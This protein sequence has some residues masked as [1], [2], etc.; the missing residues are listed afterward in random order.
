[1]LDQAAAALPVLTVPQQSGGCGQRAA[2]QYR[3]GI[4]AGS[5]PMNRALTY[6]ILAIA[7]LIACALIP[8]HL[9]GDLVN[10]RK[11]LRDR[12]VHD[13]A[14]SSAGPQRID[15]IAVVLPCTETSDEVE[16]TDKG[17][18]LVRQRTKNCD[19]HVLADRLRIEAEI[20]PQIRYR[21]I[22]PALVY[23]ARLRMEGT[24]N[25]APQAAHGEA[26][27]S[28]GEARVVLGI[29][30]VRG[31]R[32]APTLQWNDVSI[33]FAAGTGKSPFSGGIQAAVPIDA[34]RGVTAKVSLAVEL[35][36]M[37]RVD[38]VPAAGDLAVS[39]RA[40][41]PHPSFTG[42]F[43]PDTRTVTAKGFEA[44]W[45]TTDLASNIRQAFQR[46]VQG[47]CDEY[48]GAA[49]G[50]SLIQTVD[51]YQQSYRA[52][53]YGL[54]IVMLTF[55]MFLLFELLAGLRVHPV[56]YGL[57]GIALSLFFILLLAFAEH[58]AFGVAYAIAAAACVGLI[59]CYVRYVLGSWA[60]AA[61]LGAVLT[62][63]YGALFLVLGSEDYALL[64]GALLVFCALAAFML[65]TRRLDWY[66]VGMRDRVAND[67]AA[68]AR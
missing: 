24:F 60:R 63:L 25:L 50:V 47:K 10:E 26:K 66:Q 44:N 51:V 6:K 17:Q 19:V 29:S 67:A 32:S 57:V 33:P 68:S 56:Q 3:L 18:Q 20:E 38:I 64:T 55:A 2:E 11:A 14:T 49:F 13:M 12:V 39:L 41:W 52:L 34:S 54:M 5:K 65:L 40:P 35:S 7:A 21:G 45:Q 59:T 61:G 37:E 53:R 28:W 36:G 48:Y 43:L 62:A 4:D 31:I 1:M 23:R 8:M 9:A 27:R 22:Y 58:M 46:C 42:R 15:G 16:T 30:D